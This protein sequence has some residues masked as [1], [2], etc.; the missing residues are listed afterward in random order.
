[1]IK[2][3]QFFP[4]IKFGEAIIFNAFVYHG[5]Q[6]HK[7]KKAR[8]SLDVRFIRFDKPFLERYTDF[9]KKIYL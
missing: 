5:A 1:M 7:N 4:K 8:I 6:F 3:Y 2:K 9:F